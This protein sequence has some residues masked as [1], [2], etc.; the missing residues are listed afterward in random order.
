M[1]FRTNKGKVQKLTE[2]VKNNKDVVEKKQ[3][4]DITVP[5]KTVLNRPTSL[6]EDTI[7]VVLNSNYWYQS[8]N[9]G[10]NLPYQ[11]AIQYSKT[12]DLFDKDL[13]FINYHL[14]VP[15]NFDYAQFVSLNDYKF[16]SRFAP[17]TI[18]VGDKII[19]E[20]SAQINSY[21]VAYQCHF[22]DMD[23]ATEVEDSGIK[24]FNLF[25]NTQKTGNIF[26][27]NG[28]FLSGSI[29]KNQIQHNSI[30]WIVNRQDSW[31]IDSDLT[32][33]SYFSNDRI[34]IHKL[35][36]H[37]DKKNTYVIDMYIPVFGYL[38]ATKSEPINQTQTTTPSPIN[39]Y[40]ESEIAEYLPGSA[41]NLPFTLSNYIS[42]LAEYSG[43]Y[44]EFEQPVKVHFYLDNNFNHLENENVQTKN[45]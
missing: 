7:N 41:V 14:R 20:G 21:F 38:K 16:Y 40:E 15:S 31:Y 33:W 5:L 25:S 2:E 30:T 24:K 10:T 17:H 34:T 32:K 45:S 11:G 36:N 6:F 42:P 12:I 13:P 28:N 22:V 23:Y 39:V 26:F 8:P 27:H 43:Q 37:K 18:K 1:K 19:Y 44:T 9:S 29:P 4:Q 35:T 3:P